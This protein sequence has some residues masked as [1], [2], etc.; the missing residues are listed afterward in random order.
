MPARSLLV[1]LLFG[2]VLSLAGASTAA[3][4]GL[5]FLGTAPPIAG[6]PDATHV[7]VSPDGAH[8]YAVEEGS[9]T[10]IAIYARAAATGA[11]TYVDSVCY[12]DC[13]VPAVLRFVA[14]AFSP[15]GAQ[16][17]AVDDDLTAGALYVFNRNASTGVLTF[18]EK[19]QQ[20]LGGVAGLLTAT[21]VAVSGD[22]KH[23]YV[24][25]DYDPAVVLF[26]RSTTTGQLTFVQTYFSSATGYTAFTH[27]QDV[28]LSPNGQHL[29]VVGNRQLTTLSRNAT[30]GQLTVGQVIDEPIEGETS[31]GSA[32]QLTVAPDG[33][34]VYVAAVGNGISAYSRNATTGALTFVARI[35]ASDLDVPGD[36]VRIVH[37]QPDGEY[38][39][40]GSTEGIVV[41]RRNAATGRLTYVMTAPGR[42]DDGLAASADGKHLYTD[43]A[44]EIFA[45]DRCGND[46]TVGDEQC[47]DGNTSG[48]DGC[49]A[50]CQLELCGPAPSGTCR[51]PIAA[52]K[53]QLFLR[54]SPLGVRD[55]ARWTWTKGEA[56]TVAEFG[57]PLS[58]ASYVLCVY[59][60]SGASQPL[61][62]LAAVRG[63][64]CDG[65]PC[66]AAASVHG[67]KYKDRQLTPNG[68]STVQLREG[69]T[70]GKPRLSFKGKGIYLA[71]PT[72]PLAFPVTVQVRNTQ[73]SVCW[74]STFTTPLVNTSQ[75]VKAL[76]D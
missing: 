33:A 53:S 27:P 38:V 23:V 39:Y 3:A 40:G 18:V 1:S 41:Y 19:H 52:G 76:S 59:D 50:S 2:A 49:S 46:A 62:N 16:L 7:A 55:S 30:T 11:L 75:Q 70:D 66:W 47:D 63:G 24:S 15:T 74:S 5:T 67:Y 22:G 45:I 60:G 10:P 34:H 71:L 69:L 54:R 21:G 20:G 31:I 44:V 56:T 17:Y 14:V 8:V 48:G 28:V 51:E 37:V 61:L 29:Y 32:R 26:A 73:T 68:W 13:V 25:S 4:G 65:R 43:S 6:T 42:H 58:T 57:N 35:D 36:G 12:P 72:T 64:S 9:T